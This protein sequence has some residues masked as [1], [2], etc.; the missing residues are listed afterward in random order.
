[1]M[2]KDC[3]ASPRKLCAIHAATDNHA[4]DEHM[5]LVHLRQQNESLM[6]GYANASKERDEFLN[7]LEAARSDRD[8]A[9]RRAEAVLNLEDRKTLLVKLDRSEDARKRLLEA[10]LVL[11]VDLEEI[12][13]KLARALAAF[14]KFGHEDE[15]LSA[16]GH[17]D[18]ACDCSQGRLMRAALGAE[19]VPEKKSQPPA[20]GTLFD[21]RAVAQ[22]ME[23]AFKKAW[24]D[25]PVRGW[26]PVAFWGGT[27]GPRDVQAITGPPWAANNLQTHEDARAACAAMET[28]RE[29]DK[30]GGV[31]R[32]SASVQVCD[33][34]PPPETF[35]REQVHNAL[36]RAGRIEGPMHVDVAAFWRILSSSP[37]TPEA[38]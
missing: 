3:E 19:P 14:E 30:G 37:T 12:R 24:Q 2:C 32:E 20:G 4:D 9:Q 11:R 13:A 38:K 5:E 31:N 28:T 26:G 35:T 16:N 1:M 7:K 23:D 34:R 27:P 10:G 36:I 15:C 29:V 21:M 6:I 8:E 18:Y 22:G 25:I 33:A 17:P